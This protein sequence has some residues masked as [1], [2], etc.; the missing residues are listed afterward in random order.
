MLK[1]NWFFPKHC[2][3]ISFKLEPW[4]VWVNGKPPLNGIS[5]CSPLLVLQG[6]V[7]G[8]KKQMDDCESPEARK[9]AM[10]DT[11]C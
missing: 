3:F 8:A 6:I 11:M 9:E 2:T 7:Q 10:V 4:F 1:A 5:F